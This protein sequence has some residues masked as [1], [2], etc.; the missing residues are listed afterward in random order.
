MN[1]YFYAYN[2]NDG[3]HYWNITCWD[4]ATT[5]NKGTSETWNFTIA[6]DTSPPIVHLI[7]PTDEY[8][9][10]DGN[11]TFYFNVSENITSIANCSLIFNG[12][13]NTTKNGSE[14]TN[15]AINN[16]TLHNMANGTYMWSVNCSDTAQLGSNTGSSE[17]WNLTV[18]P[19]TVGPVV[20][21]YNPPPG[22][23]D[24]DGTVTFE[25][26][27]YDYA[28]NIT[29][30]SLVFNNSIN[31]TWTNVTEYQH[32]N[33]TIY[34]ISNGNYTWY[35]N[36]T[37]NSTSY[38]IGQSEVRNLTIG[39]DKTPP[40]IDL[41]APSNNTKDTDGNITFSYNVTDYAS[42]VSSCSLIINGNINQTNNSIT[43]GITQYFYLYNLNDTQ[44]YWRIDCT[45]D[46]PSP[47][48]GSSE[49]RNLTVVIPKP[50]VTNII[51][52]STT[53]IQGETVQI[54]A[55]STNSTGSLIDTNIDIDIIRGNAKAPWWDT[56]WKY[57]VPV[58]IDTENYSR[59][60]YL[61]EKEINF[62]N[63]LVNEL[64]ITGKSL[65]TNSIRVVE[66]E[67]DNDTVEIPSIFEQ[68]TGFNPTTNAIGIVSWVMRGVVPPNKNKTYHIYF[69]TTDNP[70]ATP[71]YTEPN[72]T[73]IGSGESISFDG[74]SLNKDYL[75]ISY[76]DDSFAVQFSDGDSLSNQQHIKVQGAGALWNISINRN[77]LTNTHSSIVPFSVAVN[78]SFTTDE[79]SIVT[80]GPITKISIPGEINT[81]TSSDASINYT[82]WFGKNKIFIRANLSASFGS[83]ENNNYAFENT[84]FAYLFD[85]EN[86]G[87][88][89]YINKM[90]S[91]NKNQTHNYHGI[92]ENT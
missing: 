48:T 84:W 55:N 32:Y 38:N 44:F 30:C 67:S 7:S 88:A 13:I 46:S 26:S 87:W 6:S 56:D 78:D 31:Y 75:I 92:Q 24:T 25:W 90:E 1:Q 79:T 81:V 8:Q 29:N 64:N 9:D 41:I 50:L 73:F 43:E 63:I 45:D 17:I 15:N 54:T 34:N 21:L 85:D 14:I 82:V 83:G 40:D 42:N 86:N 39:I 11:V 68:A 20:T 49:T 62:T 52:D 3:L 70:K 12:S 18:A 53:Y 59:E 47:N 36:C 61:V 4:N 23:Q 10:V 22:I 72:Y 35:V 27:A 77:L 80:P 16:F 74:A 71:S 19:D 89:D 2:L 57:R 33:H 5:Q 58:I 66:W 91:P 76:G 69:D 51:T 28:S 65:D 37:D 60:Y